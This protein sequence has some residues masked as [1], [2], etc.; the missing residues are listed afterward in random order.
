MS[1]LFSQLV[2]DQIKAHPFA[3]KALKPMFSFATCYAQAVEKQQIDQ[4]KQA[5]FFSSFLNTVIE[6]FS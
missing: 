6:Q 5:L 1:T 3:E 4:E 2:A